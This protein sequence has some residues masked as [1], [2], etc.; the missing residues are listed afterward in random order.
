MSMPYKSGVSS[1][2][3]PYVPITTGATLPVQKDQ[4]FATD[5][6]SNATAKV[7]GFPHEPR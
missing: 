5:L 4:R 2:K 6:D 1:V 7:V 3:Y